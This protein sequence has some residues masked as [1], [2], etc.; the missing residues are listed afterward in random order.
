[1]TDVKTEYD[2]KVRS[3]NQNRCIGIIFKERVGHIGE[4]AEFMVRKAPGIGE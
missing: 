2:R 1:M 3:G 4:K